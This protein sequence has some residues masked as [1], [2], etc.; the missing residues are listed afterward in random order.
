MLIFD[1]IENKVLAN[2]P[3]VAISAVTSKEMPSEQK[4]K[5]I[6]KTMYLDISDEASIFSQFAKM[7]ENV[8]VKDCKHC[9]DWC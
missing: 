3:V 2:Y 1:F 5:D 8:R 6:L 4:D 9:Y 7:F